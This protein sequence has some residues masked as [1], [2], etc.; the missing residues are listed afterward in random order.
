MLSN[1]W[2]IVSG[3]IVEINEVLLDK[4]SLLNKKPETDGWIFKIEMTSED[5]LGTLKSEE[6]YNEFTAGQDEEK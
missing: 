5:D 2:E 4:P 6:E 3:T 1:P